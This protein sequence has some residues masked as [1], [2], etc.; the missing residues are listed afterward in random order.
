MRF[1]KIIL[2]TLCLTACDMMDKP[3][4]GPVDA[5][6][7]PPLTS[8]EQSLI[9]GAEGA[10]QQSNF[11]AAERDYQSAIAISTGH[12]EAHIALAKLYD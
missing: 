2:L 11:A 8:R 7:L 5:S 12:I 6:S 9:Y 10:L 3:V 1:P 4:T